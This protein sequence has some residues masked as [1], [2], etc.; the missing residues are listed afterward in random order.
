MTPCDYL[1]VYGTLRRDYKNDMAS[2]LAQHTDFVDY[3]TYQGKLY[4]IDDYPGVIASDNSSDTV[5]GEVYRLHKPNATLILLDSYEECSADFPNH[6]E[7]IRKIQP[8]RLQKGEVAYAWVY[9]YNKPTDLLPKITSG[10]FLGLDP[11][12]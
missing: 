12:K 9:L 10:N 3:A 8:I 11:L 7:Y 6:A 2:F 1:F 5:H 4:L